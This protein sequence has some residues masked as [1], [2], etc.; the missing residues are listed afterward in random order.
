VCNDSE[1][2][3]TYDMRAEITDRRDFAAVRRFG[4]NVADELEIFYPQFLRL[5]A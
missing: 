5:E 1:I 2:K 3:E 4:K